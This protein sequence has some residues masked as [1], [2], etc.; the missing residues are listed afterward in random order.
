MESILELADRLKRQARDDVMAF[1]LRYGIDEE[2]GGYWTSLARDGTRYG[3]GAKWIV[4]Q[5]RTVYSMALAYQFFGERVFL[6]QAA[7]G[8]AFFRQHFRDRKN[9]GWFFCVSRDGSQVLDSSKQPYGTSFVSYG[10]AEYARLSGDGDALQDAIA[11]HDLIMDKCWDRIWGGLP[12]KFTDDW[13]PVDPLKRVDTHMHTMEGVSALYHATGDSRYLERLNLLANTI[14]GRMGESGCYDTEHSVT[15]EL[16]H[17]DWTEAVE[18]TKGY[19]N[20]GHVTEAGWF[21]SKLAAYTGDPR[22]WRLAKGLVDW[23]IR[24]GI[25][26]ERGGLYDLGNSHGEVTGPTKTWW[27]QAEL[28]GALAFLYRVTGEEPYLG[29]LREH[30]DYIER[31]FLDR[32]YGEWY[33]QLNADGSIVQGGEGPRDQKGSPWKSPYHVLQGLY[34]AYHDLRRAAGAEAVAEPKSWADYCL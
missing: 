17:T 24:Y 10:L 6:D 15:H 5:M 1:W 4:V 22:Q 3:D 32:E 19:S 34:H 26:P 23:A 11:T 13:Q 20:F 14:L 33:P 18:R 28:L 2:Y 7:Q 29:L 9:G 31:E 27:N 12:N 16:F 8:A 30:V 21:I 25:D